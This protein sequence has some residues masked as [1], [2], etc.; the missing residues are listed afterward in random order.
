MFTFKSLASLAAI[1]AVLTTA[2]PVENAITAPALTPDIA[3]AIASDANHADMTVAEFGVASKLGTTIVACEHPEWQGRCWNHFVDSS[4]CVNV[5]WELD[6]QF[7]SIRN[8]N[9]GGYICV[10]YEH[11]NCEGSAYTNQHDAKLQ[12]G[13][14]FFDDRIS[15]LRCWLWT[16]LSGG[17]P[18]KE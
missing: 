17:V 18:F 12:D 11:F 13:S 14:G 2:A 8:T 15:S 3:A 6:N 10:W 1:M 4:N 9:S 5:P 16:P 7:S